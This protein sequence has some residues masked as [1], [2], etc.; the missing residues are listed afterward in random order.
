MNQQVVEAFASMH[1]LL[2]PGEPPSMSRTYSNAPAPAPRV[3]MEHESRM[4]T[5]NGGGVFQ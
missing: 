1:A 4:F 2:P 5:Q 3:V